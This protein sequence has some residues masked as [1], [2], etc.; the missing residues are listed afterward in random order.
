MKSETEISDFEFDQLLVQ[1]RA[2]EEHIPDLVREDSPT[3]RVGGTISKEFESVTHRFPMLSLGNTY[4]EQELLDFDER[5]QKGLDGQSYEYICELKFDGVA[6]SVWYE[7]GV[8]T[9]GVTRGDG[10]RGDDITANVKT[11]RTLPLKVMANGLPTQFEVRGEGFCHWLLFEAINKE[12]E[13]IGEALWPIQEMQ[14]LELSKCRILLWW[15]K[16]NSIFMY[17]N[18]YQKRLFLIHTR[19]VYTG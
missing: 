7:N 19:I 17:I 12:R 14:P 5:V 4:N 16:E 18:F 9:R 15:R 3:H 1:L 11:I 8:I 6:L 2:L 13:D 10:V